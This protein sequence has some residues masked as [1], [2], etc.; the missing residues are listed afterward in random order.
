[1]TYKELIQ[2]GTA[3]LE[4]N[5]I[6]DAAFDA[7]ELLYGV[8]GFSRNS[9]MLRES[10][11]APPEQEAAYLEWITR[12][13]AHEPLQYI[14]GEWE[15]YGL[16]FSVGEG[17]LIPRPETELIVDQ[18][19]EYVSNECAGQD[20]IRVL[21]LCAGSGCI[22]QTICHELQNVEVYALEKSEKAYPYLL[23]NADALS[24]G[25]R[26][27]PMHG[28]LFD[29]PQDLPEFDII[30]SNPPYIITE[31]LPGLQ[32]EVQQEP[33]MALDGGADGLIFYRAIADLWLPLLKSGGLMVVE[34]GEEQG[35][36]IASILQTGSDL[37]K[38]YEDYA[39]LTR[40]VSL[41]RGRMS[42]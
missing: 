33:S 29:G 17:V 20:L 24:L 4:Q 30:V 8:S 21:D 32:K 39:G 41:L 11:P 28:D 6:D 42:S 27:H 40:G 15:F 26:Y 1:M 37:T 5:S 10:E 16:P 25:K 13:C 3:M 31:E 19:L 23:K 36:D 14:L 22:G 9:L 18:V 7:R 34:C 2:A 38:I 35:E 12:R